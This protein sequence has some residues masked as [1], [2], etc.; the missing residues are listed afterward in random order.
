MGRRSTHKKR[1]ALALVVIMFVVV[2]F[3]LGVQSLLAYVRGASVTTVS[4]VTSRWLTGYGYTLVSAEI[5]PTLGGIDVVI[6][7]TGE[8]PPTSALSEA[9]TE[10]AFGLDVVLEVIPAE[11]T[12]ISTQ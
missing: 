11:R 7:G 10:K 6:Q 9:L 8:L 5:D 2:A 3:P 4:Q 1:I 12:R